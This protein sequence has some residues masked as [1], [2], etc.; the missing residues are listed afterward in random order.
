MT[1]SQIISAKTDIKTK[2]GQISFNVV[3]NKKMQ[4]VIMLVEFDTSQKCLMSLLLQKYASEK[5]LVTGINMNNGMYNVIPGETSI[6]MT[7]PENRIT[8]NISILYAYLLKAKLTSQQSK[9]CSEGNY[10]KLSSD[11]KSF[12]VTIT[13]KC[14]NFVRALKAE[15][16]KIVRLKEFIGNATGSERQNVESGGN[17]L[18]L[19]EVEFS[20][21]ADS[22]VMLYTS[23]LLGNIPAKI[24]KGGSGL[25]IQFLTP[26]G[27]QLM[28]TK[29]LWKDTMQGKCKSFLTQTGSVGTQSANDKGGEK[30]KEKCSMILKC[31]NVLA[32]IYSSVRSFDY[33]YA[34]C[35]DLKKVNSTSLAM[36]KALKLKIKDA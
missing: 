21:Q 35:K 36:T 22:D 27:P 3:H 13:G 28:M 19:P 26:F 18:D 10:S 29:L 11:I 20:T 1:S 9:Y 5:C 34:D 7:I 25:K 33:S 6:A 23:I 2:N 17:K 32:H 30:Y 31:E 8:Q 15:A 14:K 24:K 16:P 12:K 4:S